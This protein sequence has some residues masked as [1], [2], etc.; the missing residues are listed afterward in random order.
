[1]GS[2]RS[3]TPGTVAH[4]RSAE[5]PDAQCSRYDAEVDCVLTD[6]LV[7]PT[8]V[9]V[10]QCSATSHTLVDNCISVRLEPKKQQC[11]RAAPDAQ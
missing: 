3:T 10:S 7:S 4:S 1:M 2:G 11:A 9:N 8:V 5:R 6:L